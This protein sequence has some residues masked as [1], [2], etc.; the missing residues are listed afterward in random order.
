MIA[1]L[2]LPRCSCFQA[3]NLNLY[4][5][6]NWRGKE[7][8]LQGS[9][10]RRTS[11][12]LPHSLRLPSPL[13]LFS[14]LQVQSLSVELEDNRRGKDLVSSHPLLTYVGTSD[15]MGLVTSQGE[16]LLDKPANEGSYMVTSQG[17][18]IPD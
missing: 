1:L 5:E 8:S 6:G 11:T 13:P 2:P 12:H 10:E 3:Q 14:R 15:L 9:R 18:M 4:L 16:K 7:M 17:E